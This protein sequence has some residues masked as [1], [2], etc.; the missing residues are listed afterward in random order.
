MPKKARI[1]A[2]AVKEMEMYFRDI[3]GPLF[4]LGVRLSRHFRETDDIR[5]R[6]VAFE[7]L[8]KSYTRDMKL[9]LAKMTQKRVSG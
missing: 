2:K 3:E 6:F 7:M 5:A 9:E 1:N 8:F 4:R